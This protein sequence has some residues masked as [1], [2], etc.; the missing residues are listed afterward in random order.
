MQIQQTAIVKMRQQLKYD[1]PNAYALKIVE[2]LKKK[3]I[4]V[5]RQ[6]TY[7]FFNGTAV[8][9]RN[10]IICAAIELIQEAK[11]ETEKLDEWIKYNL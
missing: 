5:T 8:S 6:Q 7:N 11:K 4:N 9:Q 1:Y 10:D 3:G 2:K